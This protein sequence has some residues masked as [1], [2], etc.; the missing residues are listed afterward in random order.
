MTVPE[1]PSNLSLIQTQLTA[2]TVSWTASPQPGVRYIVLYQLLE[3]SP[4]PRQKTSVL[5]RTQLTLN[6]LVSGGTY[7]ISVVSVDDLF[8]I[9]VDPINI[10]LGIE[11]S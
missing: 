6:G 4:S 3:P 7:S 1:P 8:S 11:Y 2:V 5:S 9:E 10:T